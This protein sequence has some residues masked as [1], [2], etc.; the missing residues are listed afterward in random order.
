LAPLS[1]PDA[2]P[3]WCE[4]LRVREEDRDV[5]AFALDPLPF[6][7]DL[8]GEVGRRPRTEIAGSMSGPGLDAGAAGIT[9]PGVGT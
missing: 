9:E 8:L 5:A 2:L 3:V 6:A 7:E 1:L 4:S